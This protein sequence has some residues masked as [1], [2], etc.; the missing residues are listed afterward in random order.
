MAAPKA[1]RLALMEAT[2]ANVSPILVI[3]GASA[4]AVTLLAEVTAR[5]PVFAA[6]DGRGDEHRLWV[7]DDSSEIARLVEAA[8]GAPVTIADGHHRYETA[9]ELPRLSARTS[10]EGARWVLA[11]L[12]AEDDAPALVVLAD[13]PPASPT[14]TPPAE[15]RRPPRARS[16]RSSR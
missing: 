8:A 2:Q 3:S 13:A 15:L 9:L 12:V 7:I 6:T 5:E 16:T 14:W 10:D 4:D 1:E 11:G